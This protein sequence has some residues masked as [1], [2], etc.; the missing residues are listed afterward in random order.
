MAPKKEIRKPQPV[1]AS[2]SSSFTIPKK[3]AETKPKVEPSHP[4]AEVRREKRQLS[5]STSEQTP[6]RS[7]SFDPRAEASALSSSRRTIPST[8]SLPSSPRKE[9]VLSSDSDADPA[10]ETTSSVGEAID[11]IQKL[12]TRR[13]EE[14]VCMNTFLK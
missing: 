5:G 4:Q 6:K 10:E 13:Q 14:E 12:S 2:S 3:K 7:K 11:G 1:P 8:S 9:I